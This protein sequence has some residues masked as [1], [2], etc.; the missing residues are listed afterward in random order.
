MREDIARTFRLPLL[1]RAFVSSVRLHAR[2]RLRPYPCLKAENGQNK[3]IGIAF[4]ASL[5]DS[6]SVKLDLLG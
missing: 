4:K 5:G 1:P 6:L 2:G 3:P